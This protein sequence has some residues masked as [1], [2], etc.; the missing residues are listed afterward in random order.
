M[1]MSECQKF[2]LPCL[3]VEHLQINYI[4]FHWPA[5]NLYSHQSSFWVS[6]SDHELR[7]RGGAKKCKP[8]FDVLRLI[9]PHQGWIEADCVAALVPRPDGADFSVQ[10][11]G[12]TLRDGIY[13]PQALRRRLI[14]LKQPILISTCNA[15]ICGK[16]LKSPN[17]NKSYFVA[18]DMK[19]L[20]IKWGNA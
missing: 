8:F 4:P 16:G 15:R 10:I 3:T 11:N 2:S 12:I 1:L 19:P 6:T 13:K 7:K 14:G 9:E 20:Q 5:V 17:Q 18:L